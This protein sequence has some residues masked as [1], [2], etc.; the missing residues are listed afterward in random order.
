MGKSSPGEMGHWVTPGTPSAHWEPCWYCP[1]Q[2]MLVASSPSFFTSTVTRSPLQTTI[3][4]PGTLTSAPHTCRSIT[5][6]TGLSKPATLKFLSTMDQSKMQCREGPEQAQLLVRRQDQRHHPLMHQMS[7]NL[8][9]HRRLP[10]R[11]GQRR[12][13][14]STHPRPSRHGHPL[15]VPK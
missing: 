14:R 11:P 3:G 4:G 2:W 1:C 5:V 6:K 15:L 10:Q 13:Q 12:P 7:L 9:S 8:R